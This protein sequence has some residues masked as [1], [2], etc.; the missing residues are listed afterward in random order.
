MTSSFAFS[1]AGSVC[2][3][4]V[5]QSIGVWWVCESVCVYSGILVQCCVRLCMCA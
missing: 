1:D 5:R 3:V 4:R 2:K